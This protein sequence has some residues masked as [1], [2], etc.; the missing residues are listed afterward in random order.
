MIGTYPVNNG[1]L[2]I[3]YEENIIKG[4]FWEKS[5]KKININFPFYA[6]FD[7]YFHGENVDF[8][9]VLLDFSMVSPFCKKVYELAREIPFGK[10]TSYKTIAEKLGYSK[11]LRA[12]GQALAKNPFLII[13]PCHRVIRSDGRLGN[14]SLGVEFKKFLLKLEGIEEAENGKILSL[15]YWWY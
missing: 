5:P 4:I 15:R 12:V 14:F 3:N 2:V 1:Y 13:I 10:I 6:L 7:S 11:G 9:R 8:S